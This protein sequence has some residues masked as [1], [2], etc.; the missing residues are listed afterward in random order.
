MLLSVQIKNH[1]GFRPFFLERG[2]S[3][4]LSYT[5]KYVSLADLDRLVWVAIT[6]APVYM[7]ERGGGAR[8]ECG[9]RSAASAGSEARQ[10]LLLSKFVSG[11]I[12]FLVSTTSEPVMSTVVFDKTTTEGTFGHQ[13]R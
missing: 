5:L 3:T 11:K 8:G 9:L 12:F 4:L 10:A 13:V 7:R 1:V 2:D 6:D